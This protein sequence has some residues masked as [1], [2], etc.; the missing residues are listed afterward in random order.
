MK[1]LFRDGFWKD[2][3]VALLFTVL[4]GGAVARGAAWAVDRAFS[5]AVQSLIGRYGQF[6]AI[7]HVRAEAAD[8]AWPQLRQLMA[9]R[10]PQ[11][12]LQRG[13]AVAG[14]ANFF[15]ALP[16]DQRNARQL[17]LWEEAVASL[18]GYAGRTLL[19]EPSVAVRGVPAGL[20]GPLLD[21]LKDVPG[22]A[23]VVPDGGDVVA[24]LADP[25]QASQATAEIRRRVAGRLVVEVRRPGGMP[26]PDPQ[27]ATRQAVQAISAL[28]PPGAPAGAVTPLPA[29]VNPD[30]ARLLAQLRDLRDALG[31]WE[32]GGL[33]ERLQQSAEAASRLQ[34]MARQAA[35]AARS[36]AQTLTGVGDALNYVQDLAQQIEQLQQLSGQ[37]GGPAQPG[38]PQGSVWTA[39]LS[40]LTKR[41]LGM[42]PQAV[43]ALDPQAVARLQDQLTQLA[44]RL[45]AMAE[46]EL[47][48]PDAAGQAALDPAQLSRLVTVLDAYI[49]G[50]EAEYGRADD[51]LRL[52][53]PAGIEAGALAEALRR[54]LDE[55]E[56]TLYT[57][58]AGTVAPDLRTS[59]L[60]LAGQMGRAV[61]LGVAGGVVLLFF[62]LDGA[63]VC[64]ALRHVAARRQRRRSG[65]LLAAAGLGGLTGAT[66]WPLVALVAGGPEAGGWLTLTLL[67]GGLLGG[68]LG[69]ISQ[70][71]S[72][73]ATDEMEAGEALGLSDAQIMRWI[74][75]P[76]GRPGVLATLNRLWTRPV[77][78]ARSA[79]A[80]GAGEAVSQSSS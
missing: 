3:V 13:V 30:A 40:G 46:L 63:T 49:T 70:R 72:P 18:P 42:Q 68:V 78:P 32:R 53:I 38:Q 43:S 34:A 15:V 7:V 21:L 2:W 66:L 55:P 52:A 39:L 8:A 44:D 57:I 10:W 74:V 28:V 4:L 58:S 12:R 35:E 26:W 54:A 51:R 73:V 80:P 19:L 24:V 33:A 77:L 59:V 11:A 48:A 47:P 37:P 29:H 75:V 17:A 62:L 60:A 61:A 45:E 56:A 14:K 25:G 23:F 6:D 1:A 79:A 27:R 65:P 64:S 76:A 5:G 36:A 16:P 69:A 20:Q 31:A 71:I 22:V 67:G 50:L 9:R 41:L